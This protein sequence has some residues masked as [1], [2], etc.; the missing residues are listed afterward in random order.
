MLFN[1]SCL[2]I[3]QAG[4]T[5]S[6]RVRTFF[7]F[8]PK[9]GP[10]AFDR[11]YEVLEEQYDWLARR[12]QESLVT[13]REKVFEDQLNKEETRSVRSTGMCYTAM[14]FY[15]SVILYF[16]KQWNHM[17]KNIAKGAYSTYL[18]SNWPRG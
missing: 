2:K 13:E 18:F 10:A 7:N 8:L 17:I 4:K 1:I 6:E 11:F 15:L 9:R 3:L 12:L 16:V 5:D 14:P